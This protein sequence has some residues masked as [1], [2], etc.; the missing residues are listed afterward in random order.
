[1]QHL[2]LGVR[3][4]E[5]LRIKETAFMLVTMMVMVP[6]AGW[7]E[8]AEI[9]LPVEQLNILADEWGLDVSILKDKSLSDSNSSS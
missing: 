1:M 5:N 6:L 3:I 2:Y 9:T 4:S 7:I 8:E